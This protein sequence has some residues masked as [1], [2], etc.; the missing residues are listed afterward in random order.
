M[1]N[2]TGG[3]TA[4][5]VRVVV[6]MKRD[7]E[8]IDYKA[9]VGSYMTIEGYTLGGRH[10]VRQIIRRALRGGKPLPNRV[11][12]IAITVARQVLL[13]IDA[14]KVEGAAAGMRV[15]VGEYSDISIYA[16]LRY[17]GGWIAELAAILDGF[18]GFADAWHKIVK[19]MNFGKR[20]DGFAAGILLQVNL[21]KVVKC[22]YNIYVEDDKFSHLDNDDEF[23]YFDFDGDDGNGYDDDDSD[24]GYD[25]DDDSS[26]LKIAA[27]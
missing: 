23:D 18:D 20:P 27:P 26:S 3:M 21:L 24:N 6:R 9:K 25:D 4:A 5:K 8:Y 15:D 2:T 1:A 13:W 14:Y 7:G 16:A 10:E 12:E 11:K 19:K 17:D 22:A